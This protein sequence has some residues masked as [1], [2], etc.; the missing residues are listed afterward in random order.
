MR[1]PSSTTS[2]TLTS[3]E[4]HHSL[5]LFE[6]K[7]GLRFDINTLKELLPDVETLLFFGKVYDLEVRAC[8]P[9]PE[10]HPF[11]DGEKCVACHSNQYYDPRTNTCL[12]CPSNK[13]YDKTSKACTCTEDAPFWNGNACIACYLPQYFDLDTVQCKSCKEGE[14][15]DVGARVCKPN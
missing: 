14:C 8:T 10:D 11:F 7:P 13:Q 6:V 3:T 15:F 5:T 4:L 9:C 12:T 1:T 2:T